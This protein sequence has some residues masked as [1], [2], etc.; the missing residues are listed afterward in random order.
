MLSGETLGAQRLT[1]TAK[2]N[3]TVYRQR[4]LSKCDAAHRS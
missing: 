4:G 1:I 2:G 3:P